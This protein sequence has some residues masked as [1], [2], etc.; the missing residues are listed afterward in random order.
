MI[1]PVF[2]E[3]QQLHRMSWPHVEGCIGAVLVS[4]FNP[5]IA[6]RGHSA[7]ETFAKLTVELAHWWS[8]WLECI[9]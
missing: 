3:D 1:V 5:K 6:S 2:G 9:N 7:N 8:T 4:E